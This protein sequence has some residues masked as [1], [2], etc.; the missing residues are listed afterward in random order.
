VLEILN[1]K[2]KSLFSFREVAFNINK[3][4][5]NEVLIY[6]LQVENQ[7]NI[8]ASVN[9]NPIVR[10]HNKTKDIEVDDTQEG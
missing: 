7:R 10:L 6:D 2:D 1:K 8:I 5:S 4:I 9:T 3:N